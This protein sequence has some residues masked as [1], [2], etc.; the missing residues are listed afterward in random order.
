EVV[1]CVVYTAKQNHL[2]APAVVGHGVRLATGWAR[3][4][5]F[6][7]CCSVPL[8]GVVE[9]SR[10]VSHRVRSEATKHDGLAAGAVVSHR[11]DEAGWRASG[12]YLL[13]DRPVPLPGVTE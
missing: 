2:A 9:G 10:Q 13:P 7:P 8:P 12:R 5:H 3:Y 4:R 1:P 6:C 11:V